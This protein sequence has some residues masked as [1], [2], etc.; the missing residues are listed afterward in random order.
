[1]AS[2]F[3]LPAS[4]TAPA[5]PTVSAE[6]EH[7][8]A[9]VRPMRT[10]R[11]GTAFATTAF[12]PDAADDITD[13]DS[14]FVQFVSDPLLP[15]TI[16]AQTVAIQILGNETNAGNNCFLTWKLFLCSRD[17]TSIGSTILA[18]R[19]DATELVVTTNTNRSDSATSTQVTAALGDRVVLE[20]GIGGV[21]VA[22][23]GV[24]GHNGGLRFGDSSASD[25]AVDDTA[26][27]DANPWLEFPNTL[28]FEPLSGQATL[29]TRRPAG[30]LARQF[31]YPVYD[32]N[33]GNA[34]L[35][36]QAG[37]VS[38]RA[39]VSWIQIEVP[40]VL[41]AVSLPPGQGTF[42]TRRPAAYL[43][44]TF[45]Y[46]VYDANTGS[47][48]LP[49]QPSGGIPPGQ[50]TLDTR[51]PI[52]FARPPYRLA[53]YD[54]NAGNA[55]I[56]ELVGQDA[57]G[58]S[59]NWE[60]PWVYYTT[61]RGSTALYTIAAGNP[62]LYG[63]V[64]QAS[65][66]VGEQ[67]TGLPPRAPVRAIDYS[68]VQPVPL[69]LLSQDAMD[70]GAQ[71]FDLPPRGA[72]RA[73]PDVYTTADSS[74]FWMLADSVNPGQQAVE[75]PPRAP[76][77][78][79]D[80]TFTDAS[81]VWLFGTDAMLVGAQHSA[82][83][84]VG[85]LRSRDYSL[86]Q[87]FP[88]ALI[89]QDALNAGAQSDEI[90]PRA[91]GR[92]RDYS[93][94]AGLV[95]DLVG[96]DAMVSGRQS[97]DLPPIGQ[98]RARDYSWVPP[99][100]LCCLTTVVQQIPYG[101]Q[102]TDS[103]PARAAARARDYTHTADLIPNLIGQDALNAGAQS[104]ALAPS[105]SP[106][107]ARDYSIV[108]AF[109]LVLIGQDAVAAGK[110]SFDLPP[111][112]A[113]RA[114]DY[115]FVP[116][117][118]LSCL[119]TVV[120]QIPAGQQSTDSLPPRAPTR[121][122]DYSVAAAF[123]LEL[124]GRDAF[125][126]GKQ[127][128][129]LPP[130]AAARASQLVD[131]GVNFTIPL[132]AAILPI[133]TQSAEL[134]A[135]AP[136]RAREY[137]Q[138]TRGTGYLGKDTIYGANGEAPSYDYPNPR[139][140]QRA[141]DYTWLQSFALYVYQQLP[142]GETS[143]VTEGPPRGPLRARDYTF[144]DLTKQQLIGQDVVHGAPG[145]VPTY[146]WQLPTPP[147]KRMQDYTILQS[148]SLPGLAATTHPGEHTLTD[149]ALYVHALSDSALFVHTVSDSLLIESLLTDSVPVQ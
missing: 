32:A 112:A 69:N 98:L 9:V 49:E 7:N 56:P 52:A 4:G 103:L 72:A 114:R 118:N 53:S 92:L 111:I 126:A 142:T 70:A 74:E 11:A 54:A 20:I 139:A 93:I 80:Y 90:P 66:P 58:G 89:G 138:G 30:Y 79:R 24:Q 129:E 125:N 120:Q 1:M 82:L 48:F 14:M 2:R 109:P 46:P 64:V 102:L 23:G 21:P 78:A 59:Q 5:S 43:A 146:D 96:A 18:I 33:A 73:T 94:T 99:L 15:Q 87:S 57:S 31:R 51:R 25:L 37:A 133:G 45:R 145:E 124:I 6:W 38:V 13:R 19:R 149:R 60:L 123:P 97:C 84:P 28:A 39:Q 65:L 95:P 91:A 67:Q 12:S 134:P 135:K 136:A 68:W 130:R 42:D 127:L 104:F 41:A 26:T 81:E 148:F 115:S 110:Q 140:P 86:T 113:L 50:A 117:I 121:A 128:F 137:G 76:A 44:K 116:P 35:P 108:A 34:F 141:R 144:L 3:Y 27:A 55:L 106:L 107:R 131:P 8:N 105:P 85:A 75:L 147:P 101:Q 83:P 63:A 62:S 40:D 119:T 47:A 17:G 77:R 61:R 22:T 100:N 16:S 88:L 36:E 29:D 132:A 71:S 122:R 143:Q 10:V